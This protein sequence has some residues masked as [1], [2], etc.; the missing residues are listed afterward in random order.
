[1]NICAPR[2]RPLPI[3]RL[4]QPPPPFFMAHACAST[5]AASAAEQ[6]G[7]P[8]AEPMDVDAAAPSG[9]QQT[10]TPP[11]QGTQEA[12]T[13]AGQKLGTASQGSLEAATPS[14]QRLGAAAAS[15]GKGGVT[16][17][18]GATPGSENEGPRSQGG[19]H[20]SAKVRA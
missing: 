9:K 13:P 14:V 19:L 2:M 4:R 5:C 18:A 7:A 10:S 16:S 1:M 15:G 6:L 12:A 3:T 8:G 11:T 17:P 20:G